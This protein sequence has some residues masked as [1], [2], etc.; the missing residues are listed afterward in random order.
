VAAAPGS[1]HGESPRDV[2]RE[3]GA[4]I[5]CV[6]SALLLR[7]V[8]EL[9]GTV[10]VA[11]VLGRSGTSRTRDYLI[12]IGNWISYDE[13]NALW[14]AATEV[15]H[16]RRLARRVGAEAGTQLAGSHV[17][18]ALRSLGSPEE[19]Y[20]QLVTTTAKYSTIATIEIVELA[21]GFAE[22]A[23]T[24]VPG[25]PRSVHLCDWVIGLF[26]QPPVLFG[27][28]AAE[29]VH[30]ACAAFGAPECRYLVS[31]QA[32]AP[33]PASADEIDRLQRELGSMRERLRG[34]FDTAADLVGSGSLDDALARIA[35]RVATEIRAPRHLL[36]VQT[37]PGEEILCHARGFSAAEIERHRTVLM[38][39]GQVS[40]PASWLTAPVSSGRRDYGYLVAA[41]PEQS[42]FLPQERESLEVYAR[43]AA[44]ALDS[45]AA[46]MQAERRSRESARLLQFSRAL[47]VAGTSWE[48]AA[49]LAESIPVLV[50]CDEVGVYLWDGTE[51]SSYARERPEPDAAVRNQ[52]L[53]RTWRPRPGGSL[54]G[55]VSDP[56]LAPIFV[57]LGH[58]GPR[59]HE[60]LRQLGVS[61]GILVPLSSRDELLGVAVAV[62][63]ERPERVAWSPE[64]SARVSG[65]AAQATVALENGRLLDV[66]THQ[67]F[68]DQLTGLANRVQFGADLRDAVTRAERDG[69]LV[70]LF[71]MDLDRFKSVNDR[72]GHAVGDELLVAVAGRLLASTRGADSVGRLGGDEFAVV[73]AASCAAELDRIGERLTAALQRPFDVRECP[74]RLAASVGR[75]VFPTDASDAEGL[76][77][78]AD[79]AMYLRKTADVQG[80]RSS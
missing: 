19:V 31:W 61:A 73:A 48:I 4:H 44:V 62:A 55:F 36:V 37:A 80:P 17:A 50:D 33:A 5:S 7:T 9:G 71:Y 76:I 18:S 52:L 57:D 65:I 43:Y 13:A 11:E 27:L 60:T 69:S 72:L 29:I 68:H 34:M 6:M 22:I 26:S 14:D 3:A 45:A 78:L 46:R 12:N 59:D 24:A 38:A 77:T 63:V 32:D 16:H 49:R 40:V 39:E 21:P 79:A 23:V 70:G 15:T 41:Y 56:G 35:E 51:F 64:L 20:R 30:D 75:A 1:D 54:E 25:Y 58:G 42:S 67:A 2:D 66:I 74:V 53:P 28:P 8:R 47:S 10:A